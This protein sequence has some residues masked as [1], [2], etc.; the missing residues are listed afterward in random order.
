MADRFTRLVDRLDDMLFSHSFTVFGRRV[1]VYPFRSAMHGA[2]DIRTKRWG[3]VCFKPPTRAF[4]R[5]WPWYFYVSPD[6][7]PSKATYYRGGRDV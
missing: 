5:W 7:T 4:G 6:A 3:W 2:I 1:F